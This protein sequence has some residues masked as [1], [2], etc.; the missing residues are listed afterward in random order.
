MNN[1]V[2]Y[3]FDRLMLWYLGI[4]MILT[5]FGAY[6]GWLYLITA[7]MHLIMIIMVVRI[8]S[9][10]R[11][12][13]P[14]YWL[15]W[16][17]PLLLMLP[18]HYEIELVGTLFHAGTTFDGLV[19]KWDQWLFRGHP[20]RYLA[21]T[22]AGPWWR[23]ILH[24]FYCSYY[25]IIG[26]GF[27]FAWHQG[28][29]AE[30]T[31]PTTSPT[32]FFYRYAFVFIGTFCTY[33]LI[34]IAF[35][36]VG[37]LDDRFLRFG[38]QGIIGPLIDL[39]YATGDSAAGAFPSSHVG[40]AVVIYL[41]FQPRKPWIR[42]A[43]VLT[44]TGLALSTVYGCFHYAIDALG[45][46]VTGPVFYLFWSWVYRQL[47]PEAITSAPPPELDADAGLAEPAIDEES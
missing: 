26:G 10:I 18:L 7:M 35:P 6:F 20:H 41:L 4:I 23:E 13:G 36:V 22:L 40:E 37:P 21:D 3:H 28:S 15:R 14:R 2:R 29:E 46:L 33:M 27:L 39:L 11:M 34:F 31:Q 47:R 45:G 30:P 24:L 17:Y 1:S 38:E 32:P 44:I 12:S 43:L 19:L 9:T 25:A 42:A 5:L 16:F 8:T